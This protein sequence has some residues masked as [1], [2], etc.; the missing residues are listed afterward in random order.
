MKEA[1]N[2]FHVRTVENIENDDTF[3]NLFEPTT[4]EAFNPDEI[5]DRLHVLRSA[6]GGGKSSLLRLFTPNCLWRIWKERKTYPQRQEL[7]DSLQKFNVFG[8]SGPKVLGVVIPCKKPYNTLEHVRGTPEAKLRLFYALIDA[9][10]VSEVLKGA[11]LLRGLRYPEDLDRVEI[12]NTLSDEFSGRI[13]IDA[14]ASELL[15]WARQTESKIW[16]GIDDFDGISGAGIGHSEIYTMQLLRRGAISVNGKPILERCVLMFDDTHKLSAYQRREL[17]ELAATSRSK[18]GVWMAER[19][20]A[21]EP[22][23][24]ISLGASTGREIVERNLAERWQKAARD[25]PR[26]FEAIGTK[27]IHE[28]TEAIHDT[29]FQS[30][31]SVTVEHTELREP[32]NRAYR[33]LRS[34][35]QERRS[36]AR[37]F[38]S[39]LIPNA[40]DSDQNLFD[41]LLALKQVEIIIE[42]NV[43]SKQKSFDF[44]ESLT[45]P[46]KEELDKLNSVAEYQIANE[47]DVPYYF[48]LDK[49]AKLSSSNIDQFLFL[50]GGIFEELLSLKI[51]NRRPPVSAKRQELVVMKAASQMWDDIPT[52]IPQGVRVQR[53]LQAIGE[54]CREK[55]LSPRASYIPGVTGFAITTEDHELLG[56]EKARDREDLRTLGDVIAWSVAHNL[57][58]MERDRRQG[59]KGR[60]LTV[61]YLNRLL[62]AHMRLP[63]GY[64]GWQHRPLPTL[65]EWVRTGIAVKS[66]DESFDFFDREEE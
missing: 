11:L 30:A 36:G 66:E 65:S 58:S 31:V 10:C 14:T 61:F 63:L 52:R 50:G 17:Q 19:L 56:S 37:L 27:R 40:E 64:G 1:R 34:R 39:L 3:L 59:R 62:C 22:R 48:G 51:R 4:L 49:M 53:F 54:Y 2:P 15:D 18:T 21:L 26:V 12:H 57:L 38:E 60:T 32:M 43:A 5:W 47:F 16:S 35:V 44:S 20:Q 45:M 55:S 28:S 23:E 6:Q 41:A 25:K 29:T 42:R 8:Q 24:I 9:R 7:Y 13:P 33:E 46:S